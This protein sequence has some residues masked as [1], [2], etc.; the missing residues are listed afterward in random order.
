MKWRDRP[1]DTFSGE[2]LVELRSELVDA[3]RNASTVNQVRRIVRGAFGTNPSSPALAWE[4]MSAKVESEG[5]YPRN[6]ETR[7]LQGIHP[8]ATTGIEPV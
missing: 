6:P 2:D 5:P 8:E 7:V 1:L 3:G 4:W